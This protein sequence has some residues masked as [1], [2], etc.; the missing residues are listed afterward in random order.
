LASSKFGTFHGKLRKLT[1][2]PEGTKKKGKKRQGGGGRSEKKK[3][4]KRKGPVKKLMKI[5]T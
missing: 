4:T 1:K 5:M 3:T 2:I